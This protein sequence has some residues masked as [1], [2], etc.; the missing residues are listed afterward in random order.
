[1]CVLFP[2]ILTVAFS[3]QIYFQTH[4]SNGF[5]FH[6]VR[7]VSAGVTLGLDQN[8]KTEALLQ[9]VVSTSRI[10]PQSKPPI[11]CT[12]QVCLVCFVF[13]KREGT[14]DVQRSVTSVK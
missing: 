7:F 4:K 1:M 13:S 8:K 3:R 9:E 11:T 6:F 12:V 14:I 5:V 10:Q 2:R